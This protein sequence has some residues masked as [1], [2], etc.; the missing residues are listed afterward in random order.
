M[1][2]TLV[3]L[4]AS[5]AFGVFALTGSAAPK[6]ATLVIKHQVRGCHSWSLNGGKMQVVQRIQ[7][8]R[9]GSLVIRNDDVM[10]H[11]LVKTTGPAMVVKLI[12][13]GM[14]GKGMMKDPFAKGM[15]GRMDATLKVTFPSKGVYRLITKPGEDY[16]EVGETIGEDNVLRAIVTVS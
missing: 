1:K 11:Q 2:R 16:Y 3:L 6:S 8:A 9:G 14:M 15:M 7:L 12:H 10:P 4:V 13:P 5:V